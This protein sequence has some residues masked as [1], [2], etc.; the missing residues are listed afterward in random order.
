VTLV[1]EQLPANKAGL[2]FFGPSQTQ[3][4]FGNGFRCAGGGILRLGPPQLSSAQGV[5]LRGV[6]LAASPALGVIAPG[7]TSNFQF[8]YRDPDASG[9]SFNL[10]NAVS[11]TW[12]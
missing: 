11:V 10:S 7:V 4:P 1:V 9:A 12:Q 5:T 3:T 8:W 6:D 2:F